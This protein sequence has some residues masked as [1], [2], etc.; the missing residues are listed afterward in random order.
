MATT[1]E[2]Y[3]L[4]GR[5]PRYTTKLSAFSNGMYLTQ[6]M[7]PEG[8]AK[9]MINYDIDDTGTCIRPRAG[10]EILQ[11][12]PF[13]SKVL[14][15]ASIT[16]YIYAYNKDETEVTTLKDMVLSYGLYTRLDSL[17]TNEAAK[18]E[19]PIY[20]AAMTREVDEALYDLDPNTNQWVLRQEGEKYTEEYNEFWGL[21]YNKEKELFDKLTNQDVGYVIA[22]TID[23]AYAF[24]KP[25]VGSVGRPIGALINNE[26]IT[27]A[28][29]KFTVKDYPNTPSRSELLNFGKP[30]LSKLIIVNSDDGTVVKRKLIEPQVLN[31]LEAASSGYNI[32]LSDPYTFENEEGG[33]LSGL[34]V[35]LYADTNGKLSTVLSCKVGQT[36]V[37]RAYY[38]YAKAGDSI[39]YKMEVLDLTNTNSDWELVKDFGDAVS[40]GPTNFIEQ[41]YVV[42]YTRFAIMFTLRKGDDT[43]TDVTDVSP[44]ISAN[45]DSSYT[46]YEN[47]TYDL[48]TGTGMISWQGCVGVYGVTGA[49]DTIFFSDIENPSYFPFPYNII[50]FDNEILAVHNYLDYLLVVTVDS[51]WLV[52]GNTTIAT[53]TQKRILANIHIPEIDAI[54]LVV[55]KD[56]IFFK[57]DNQFY[58]LKPNQYTSDAT[59]LKNYVNSTAI[60]N[61]TQTF[62]SSVVDLLNDVYVLTW[63]RLTAEHRTQI[64]FEDFDVYDTHSIIKDSEVHYIYK[65]KPKLTGGIE[66]D[67][68]NVHFVYNT[69]TRSWRMYFVAIGDDNINYN[70]VLYKNKQSGIFCEFIPRSNLSDGSTLYVTKQT[71][72]EVT[73]NITDEDWNLTTEYNNY[74]YLDTGNVSLDDT[75]TKRFREVQF[76][77]YNMENETIRFFSDFKLDGRERIHATSYELQHITDIND[78]DYGVIYVTPTE[79]TNVDLQTTTEVNSAKYGIIYMA[80]ISQ[81]NVDL[82]GTTVTTGD[83]GWSIDL[84]RF[85]ELSMATVRFTL[86]GR[87][88][89]G[90]LQLLNTSLKRY[91]LSNMN[92]VY[93]TMSAR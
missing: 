44:P 51:I 29:P 28:G 82:Q 77:L 54:N 27:F 31:P 64:R 80:P 42:K 70:P 7:I 85:P 71:R 10:R 14:G 39:K 50:Q 24:D 33:T 84:S 11:K 1:Q 92:W 9:S 41:E 13:E 8:Y 75:F 81:T 67:Y 38:Q 21:S 79:A 76:N 73:D 5:L 83:D 45:T 72:E 37:C 22:R 4:G 57:T 26:L 30:A 53:S 17:V 69:L 20:I 12:I 74:P 90:S 65:I 15:P 34:G 59:D 25:F 89:R 49:K 52:T 3:R 35:L 87:G 47:Q 60:A 93:R 61:L 62:T 88:R 16:D 46:K 68:L 63:Q 48:T 32:L 23:N 40:A 66:L 6:Q 19:R 78:P 18:K 55:L 36:V 86:Q 56:Q 43:T 91:E 2:F 58:V